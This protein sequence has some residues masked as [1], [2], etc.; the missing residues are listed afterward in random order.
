V[1][2]DILKPI[3]TIINY[4]P[5]YRNWLTFKICGMFSLVSVSAGVLATR[6]RQLLLH[7]GRTQLLELRH[8]D[9]AAGSHAEHRQQLVAWVASVVL[10][11]YT[12]NCVVYAKKD[13]GLVWSYKVSRVQSVYKNGKNIKLLWQIIYRLHLRLLSETTFCV[14]ISL[15]CE[16]SFDKK[17]LNALSHTIIIKDTT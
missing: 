8:R 5:R 12:R 15:Y 16:Y 14:V 4:N 3:T 1:T 2:L 6:G 13:W 17:K 7:E 11:T 9:V 10:G